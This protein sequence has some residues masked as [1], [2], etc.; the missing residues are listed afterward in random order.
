MAFIVD[1]TDTPDVIERWPYQFQYID[2]DKPFWKYISAFASELRHID[3]FIDE[4]YEQRFLESAS[5]IE[6]EKLAL[7]VGVTRRIQ[8]SDEK[9]RSR[10][11]LR[12]VVSTSD[13]TAGDI[14][15]ILTI[16]FGE[17]AL[18]AITVTHLDDR[19]VT[20]FTLQQSMIDDIPL[21]REELVDEL[22][23]AFPAGYGVDIPTTETWTLGESGAEGIGE[24]GLA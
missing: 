23:R 6:L 13:G 24:G 8:E 22:E 18:D 9:L 20:Q 2:S 19:P 14:E 1:K 3:V 7:E 17:D 16:T 12:K 21:S 15:G 5:G 4:L 11:Q 10:A